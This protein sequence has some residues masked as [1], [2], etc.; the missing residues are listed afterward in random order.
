MKKLLYTIVIAILLASCTNT[1]QNLANIELIEKYIKAVETEDYETMES[2]LAE[3]YLGL[4]PS[5][6]DSIR[7]PV[8]LGNWK[9][10]ITNLYE[11]ISYNK[12]RN[13]SVNVPDGE[14]KGEWV[15]N[16][17][18]LNIKYKD[19]RGEVTTWA[20]TIYKI[21]NEKIIE[22]ITFYNEADVLRQLGYVFINQNDL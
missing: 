5:Y 9:D 19:G 13:I 12:S 3:N 16:W 18:E 15:S 4:G 11:S 6:G 17:A 21:E 10:N 8:A 20:N 7:K 22:S 14:N 1:S 2:L